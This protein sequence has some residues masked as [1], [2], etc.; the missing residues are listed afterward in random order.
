MAGP[1]PGAPRLSLH[2]PNKLRTSTL[3]DNIVRPGPLR[4]SSSGAPHAA[5]LHEARS[6]RLLDRSRADQVQQQQRQQQR[7]QQSSSG[8]TEEAA[9]AAAAAAGSSSSSGG[10]GGGG[11]SSS[12]GG[13][14]G[15][16]GNCSSSG[17]SGG[18]HGSDSGGGSSSNSR[19]EKQ[20]HQRRGRGQQ[21]QQRQL[22]RQQQQQQNQQRRQQLR[23]HHQRRHE[24]RRRPSGPDP[25][26]LLTW[27]GAGPTTELSSHAVALP[28][29]GGRCPTCGPGQDRTHLS[30][31]CP[32]A[33]RT[34]REPHTLRTGPEQDPLLSYYARQWLRQSRAGRV[35]A[36]QVHKPRTLWSPELVGPCS[37]RTERG[38]HTG[39]D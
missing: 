14:G 12:G 20:Q 22:R 30:R 15:G 18:N 35:L 26:T 1:E 16:G 4:Q 32:L 6:T 29:P 34:E 23:L 8:D 27:A 11:S 37:S 10:G 24:K 25:R 36:G 38:P 21:P 28:E 33:S 39:P 2:I 31:L 13:G 3:T 9:A 7:W 19:R 17:S 5:D